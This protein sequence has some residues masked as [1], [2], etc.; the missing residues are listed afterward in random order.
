MYC[1]VLLLLWISMFVCCCI[2]I[3]LIQNT[4]RYICPASATYDFSTN[5]VVCTVLL[6]PFFAWLLC[7]WCLCVSHATL[8]H[9]LDGEFNLIYKVE[10]CWAV[11]RKHNQMEHTY[12]EK[13]K[14]VCLRA[15]ASYFL[16]FLKF[17]SR[18]IHV[19]L[20]YNMAFYGYFCYSVAAMKIATK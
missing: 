13:L 17:F 15:T 20:L 18:P 4:I 9:P 8:N 12:N 6:M 7:H 11:H 3:P 16:I 19:D 2:Q 14:V 1:V 10:K 5:K